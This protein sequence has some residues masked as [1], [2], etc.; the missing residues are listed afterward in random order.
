MSFNGTGTF[1]LNTGGYPYV[2]NTLIVSANVNTL[3]QD[4]ANG[5]SLTVTRDGQMSMNGPLHMAAQLIDGIKSALFSTTT[6]A[7][8]GDGIYLQA[9]HTL[10]ISINSS[11]QFQLDAVGGLT[12]IGTATSTSNFLSSGTLNGAT[13]VRQFFGNAIVNSAVTGAFTTFDS[14]PQTTA[15]A[16][17][18]SNL[19]HFRCNAPVIGAGSSIG[20]QHGFNVTPGM[21]GATT[22]YAFR[23][24]LPAAASNWNL[25]MDGTARSYHAGVFQLGSATDDGSGALVQVTGG[26]TLDAATNAALQL[27]IFNNATLLNTASTILLQTGTGG[28]TALI[29]LQDFVS[30]PVFQI[31][32][33]ASVGS[34]ALVCPGGSITLN[35]GGTSPFVLNANSVTLIG[36]GAG[37]AMLRINSSATTGAQTATFSATNK[38]GSGTTAP[39]KWLPVALD[40]T[41]YYIPCWQ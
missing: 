17:T 20:S 1:I 24:Q 25:Y 29:E 37:S 8:S 21:V 5:L 19:H 14:S 38:P 4:I 23:G 36:A 18:L 12:S 15:A 39:T 7:A 32:A 34:M 3:L 27:K 41:T 13:I 9:A 40:G 16:F 10:G 30:S 33:G 31:V 35:P 2:P 11:Q 28:S 6:S 26:V 22:N